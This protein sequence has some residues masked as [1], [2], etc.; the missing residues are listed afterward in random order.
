M[1]L[2]FIKNCHTVWKVFIKFSFLPSL[3]G[4][5][6]W[7]RSLSGVGCVVFGD[8]VHSS[9]YGL[10]SR[11]WFTLQFPDGPP[12][13]DLLMHLFCISVSLGKHLFSAFVC[14]LSHSDTDGFQEIFIYFGY[15]FESEMYLINISPV[16]GWCFHSQYFI[17]QK[18]NNFNGFPV[19]TMFIG[20]VLIC[21]S[22][23]GEPEIFF[24]RYLLHFYKFTSYTL[25][26]GTL[27]SYSLCWRFCVWIL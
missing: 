23:H 3:S 16:C 1:L 13:P 22:S 24:L 19:V 17:L 21:P 14:L 2:E 8:F 26:L 18:K 12:C 10:R 20:L 7:S 27:L 15:Q 9:S 11:C 6:C 4:G 25:D 5:S